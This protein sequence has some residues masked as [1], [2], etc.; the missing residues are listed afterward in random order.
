MKVLES[1]NDEAIRELYNTFVLNE[2]DSRGRYLEYRT[3]AWMFKKWKEAHTVKPDQKVEGIGQ[4]DA[5]AMDA[6]GK[7]LAFAECKSR[8]VSYEDVE[9]WLANVRRSYEKFGRAFKK[10]YLVGSR[11]YSQGVI[12][13]VK[14]TKDIDRKTGL[15]KLGAL[16]KVTDFLEK[17]QIVSLKAGQVKI[18]IYDEREGKM[19]S[20][21]P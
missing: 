17:A 16:G 8:P 6:D 3:A 4:L 21:F 18:E 2:S 13:R 1:M 19:V 7:L 11:G 15:M 10:S 9:K 14:T 5:V 12:E 20:V